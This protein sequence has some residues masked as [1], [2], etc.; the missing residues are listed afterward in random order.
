MASSKVV[1]SEQKNS[2]TYLKVE[3]LPHALHIDLT[4]CVHAR[5]CPAYAMDGALGA[6]AFWGAQRGF[7][8]AAFVHFRKRVPSKRAP[9]K[10]YRTGL[11]PTVDSLQALSW[12]AT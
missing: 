5:Q 11:S 2:C 7:V 3:I 6:S 10:G 12:P 1:A 8:L 9:H 4:Q